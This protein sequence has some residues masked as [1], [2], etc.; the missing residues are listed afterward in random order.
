MRSITITAAAVLALVVPTFGQ[1]DAD[2]PAAPA[3][4]P[5]TPPVATP[6]NVSYAIGTM[7]AENLKGQGVKVDLSELTKGLTDVMNGK[8]PRLDK[9]QCQQVMMAFQQEQAKGQAAR[10]EAAQKERSAQGK[11]AYEKAVAAGDKTA[12]AS[13]DFLATNAKRKE[14]TATAS[15]LQYEVMKEG[16]GEKPASSSS[17]TVHYHGTLPDGKVFDSSVQKGQPASFGLSQVI[18]GWTEGLQLMQKGAKYKFFVPSYLAYGEQG[19]PPDIPGNAA[20]VFEVEL[21]GIE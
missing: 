9:T 2:K 6:E 19:Y 11:A 21:L 10:M 14:V 12:V 18:P 17:V 16:A 7:I 13:R 8:E 5:A 20:L 1:K 4:Q 15:G 3:E